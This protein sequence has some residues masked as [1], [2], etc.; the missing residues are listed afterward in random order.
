MTSGLAISG[1]IPSVV[2]SS[3]FSSRRANSGAEALSA[4]NPFVGAMNM[5]IAGGQVL[6]AARNVASL[7]GESQRPLAAQITSAEESIKALAKSDKIINGVGKVLN[8]T[9]DHINPIICA[10][11]AVKVLTSDDKT[12]TAIREGLALG[13]MFA[14]EATAKKVLGMPR[15]KKFDPKTMSISNEGIYK[16][17][18]GK[19]ELIAKN[20]K[21]KILKNNRLVIQRDSIF[22]NKQVAAF[23]DFCATKR[24]F[25]KSLNFLPG[26]LKGLGFVCASIAGYKIGSTI[27]NGII[28]EKRA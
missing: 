7:A 19:K 5:D 9:A 23:N 25:N 28:G 12:D 26:A 17:V 21:Y 11:S 20:G 1:L 10:T 15:I 24:V 4:S 6:N 22:S 16:I 27:A 2:S 13:T 8:F 18:D 14:S 3:I